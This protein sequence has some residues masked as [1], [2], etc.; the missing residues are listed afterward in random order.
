MEDKCFCHLNGYEVK[1]AKA[2]RDI[3]TLHKAL[4]EKGYTNEEI[5][6]LRKE[7]SGYTN[8][9]IAKL[10]EE[11]SG[12]TNEGLSNLHYE[13]IGYT[14]FVTDLIYDGL[15]DHISNHEKRMTNIE[16]HINQNYFET[17]EMSAYEKSVPVNACTYAQINKIG[18][19]TYKHD[20]LI[21][22]P[23]NDGEGKG[24]TVIISPNGGITFSILADGGIHIKGYTSSKTV[25]RL[26][27][28]TEL[29]SKFIAGKSYTLSLKGAQEGVRLELNYIDKNEISRAWWFSDTTFDWNGEGRVN[30]LKLAILAGYTV[31]CIV[32][33]TLNEG[34]VALPYDKNDGGFKH[35]K[36]TAL[37]S[38]DENLIRV[39][40]VS[41]HE[42]I[43]AI[44]GYG[45]GN[46][47]NASEYNYI[48]FERKKFVSVGHFDGDAWVRY[49]IPKETDIS[50]YLTNEFI[51]VE[52]GGTIIADNEYEYDVP[53]DITYLLKDV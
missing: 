30:D 37:V 3:E 47:D 18:G 42:A 40:T 19:M 50:E 7:L 31:D 53:S 36:V 25:V 24:D 45:E 10:R 12:Y 48:D 26:V 44:D 14:D 6:K 2:R 4:E 39:D 49:D 5:A 32:Y 43:Q 21:H 1:D 15:E 22:F 46:P 16:K 17:D 52:G 35:A 33:P 27:T 29:T 23:Y 28:G 11:L 13:L 38:K 9:E 8:E 20:N 41:I 34:T 51:K